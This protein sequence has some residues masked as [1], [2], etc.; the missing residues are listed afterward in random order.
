MTWS[1]SRATVHADEV[2]AAKDKATSFEWGDLGEGS[3]PSS[4]RVRSPEELAAAE[5]RSRRSELESAFAQGFAQG[6]ADGEARARVTVRTGLEAIRKVLSEIVSEREEWRLQA[7]DN[8]TALALCVAR[9]LLDRELATDPGIFA[10]LVRKALASF[11][12]EQPVRIRLNPHDLSCISAIG[13]DEPGST[14]ITA[15]RE[16]QWIPD[17]DIVRGG[18]VVEGPDR[19]LDGR[20]DVCLDRIYWALNDE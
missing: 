5:D 8:L 4:D 12:P 18:C 13:E 3:D 16:T 2:V 11:P 6:S 9:Q 19:I 17:A 10:D 15:S 14:P 7:E 1:S 20:V